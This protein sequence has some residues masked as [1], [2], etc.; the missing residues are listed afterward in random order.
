MA[1]SSFPLSAE[2]IEFEKSINTENFWTAEDS[3]NVKLKHAPIEY[4]DFSIRRLVDLET[5]A[6]GEVTTPTL[7]ERGLPRSG[8]P[9]DLRG[10]TCDRTLLCQTCGH[11]SR[12][13]TGHD[14]I[15]WLP[16]P[17]INVGFLPFVVRVMR[18]VCF[19]CLRLRCKPKSFSPLLRAKGAAFWTNNYALRT[20]SI[21][22]KTRRICEHCGAVCPVIGTQKL[23]VTWTWTPRDLKEIAI[24]LRKNPGN[25]NTFAPPDVPLPDLVEGGVDPKTGRKL[26]L[27]V[28]GSKGQKKVSCII[29]SKFVRDTLL[30]ISHDDYATLGLNSRRSPPADCV[31]VAISIPPIS[32]RPTVNFSDSVRHRRVNDLTSRQQDIIRCAQKLRRLMEDQN[33]PAGGPP[34]ADPKQPPK[35]KARRSRA[36]GI[37]NATR[38]VRAE[39]SRRTPTQILETAYYELCVAMMMYIDCESSIARKIRKS[40]SR[41]GGGNGGVQQSV[42]GLFRGKSGRVRD[43]LGG[44]RL[45]QTARTVACPTQV[46]GM[47]EIGISEYIARTLSDERRVRDYN[48][49]DM[50]ARIIRGTK[51]L[52]GAKTVRRGKERADLSLMDRAQRQ[53][54]ARRLAPS[55]IVET[56]LREHQLIL[57]GRQP[58]LHLGSIMAHRARRI[59]GK[60]VTQVNNSAAG[61][62]NL[63]FDG[64]AT[65]KYLVGGPEA[66]AEMGILMPVAAR[67][68][69]SNHRTMM[70]LIQDTLVAAFRLTRSEKP[71][72]IRSG[73]YQQA[74]SQAHH[75]DWP[76]LARAMAF[77]RGDDDD[78]YLGRHLV[79]ALFPADFSFDQQVMGLVSGKLQRV[80]VCRGELVEGRLGKKTLGTSANGIIAAMSA[81]HGSTRT[82]HFM[83]DAQRVWGMWMSECALTITPEDLLLANGVRE[84]VAAMVD[85]E[86]AKANEAAARGDGERKIMQRLQNVVM[87]AGTM[88]LQHVKDSGF[89]EIISS[90]AKGSAVN[91]AQVLCC[92][93][94]QTIGGKRFGKV[95]RRTLPSFPHNS[96]YQSAE[97][98]GFVKSAF[99]DGLTF[100]ELYPHLAASRDALIA[101]VGTTSKCGYAQRKMKTEMQNSI[102]QYDG[103]VRITNGQIVSFTYGTDGM[104]GTRLVPVRLAY[105]RPWAQS[106][107]DPRGASTVYLPFDAIKRA[108]QLS[109]QCSGRR[110][111][112][113][114]EQALDLAIDQLLTKV[115]KH[116]K[117][118]PAG[119]DALSLRAHLEDARDEM[120]RLLPSGAAVTKL[121]EGLEHLYFQARI[122]AGEAVGTLS[123]DS[124][125]ELI[126]QLVLNVFHYA[127]LTS[128]AWT[129]GVPRL[130]EL[131]DGSCNISTPCMHVWGEDLPALERA[132]AFR[133]L[134]HILDET[135]VLEQPSIWSIPPDSLAMIDDR[136]ELVDAQR[137]VVHATRFLR[138]M[139]EPMYDHASPWVLL[140]V[141]SPAGMRKLDLTVL[142]VADKVRTYL[143]H[144]SRRYILESST[145]AMAVPF[146]RIRITNSGD[147]ERRCREDLQRRFPSWNEE[148]RGRVVS[149]MFHSLTHSLQR[150]LAFHVHLAGV[151][152]VT[153]AEIGTPND[154]LGQRK[155]E[156]RVLTAGSCI[157]DAWALPGIQWDRILSNDIHEVVRVLGIEAGTMA[158]FNEL[159]Q[160][161]CSGG[162]SVADRHILLLATSMTTS[163][164]FT[165]LTRFDQGRKRRGPLVR[166][167]FEQQVASFVDGACFNESNRVGFVAE[168]LMVG[169]RTPAGT[170]IVRLTLDPKYV[171]DSRAKAKAKRKVQEQAKEAGGG[172][173][174]VRTCLHRDVAARRAQREDEETQAALRMPLD[175]GFNMNWMKRCG[176]GRLT[177]G[178]GGVLRPRQVP[179]A[180]SGTVIPSDR[181]DFEQARRFTRIPIT[182]PQEPVDDPHDGTV[183][184]HVVDPVMLRRLT[185]FKPSELVLN[186]APID[187]AAIQSLFAAMQSTPVIDPNT[188]YTVEGELQLEPFKKLVKR[189]L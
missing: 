5:E 86:V 180:S 112:A 129:Q 135:H 162:S 160:V 42:F 137:A 147:I 8:G 3:R 17:V 167:D 145:P 150:K 144:D 39:R 51:H 153:V 163:G 66:R 126:T 155:D 10:G 148:R 134:D 154:R 2:E 114:V 185:H 74:L 73:L 169:A 176:M 40:R 99:I 32:M 175:Q 33:L 11:G 168:K 48:L 46:L 93:G 113:E 89:L 161:M 141:L 139:I 27:K 49:D 57:H 120:A 18:T 53:A 69:S 19:G 117:S 29:D 138:S 165:S 140:L 65:N 149:N 189:L 124:C 183:P 110:P 108:R 70:G 101:T 82:L 16:K 64:D 71:V 174:P 85:E 24:A 118:R 14:M 56:P 12:I 9:L 156:Q 178:G 90:G 105:P 111:V 166:A 44:K 80:R 62:S 182:V 78:P 61:A 188:L 26:P 115:G 54:L 130:V 4:V 34:D 60:L 94:Q 55:D 132:L 13:C 84:K 15:Y 50:R 177:K 96:P 181:V 30:A 28:V 171:A 119:S 76:D 91:L 142:D 146:L 36:M 88:A 136:P 22:M 98:R 121:F 158:L 92:I 97:S 52:D 47:A 58:T 131:L 68:R 164:R 103:T 83:D 143:G 125:G 21:H 128:I 186:A 127:G 75:L 20:L 123:S 45:N 25:P 77:A 41:M 67:L 179:E 43:N 81:Q 109:E 157:R 107:V 106:V 1:A 151:H 133:I 172:M 59:K 170:G 79:S 152:G 95:T 37:R 38:A 116:L 184:L 100:A 187:L 102:V 87:S 104:D 72:V 122:E 23:A 159:R 63:D 31:L 6:V 7:L 35:K 173:R